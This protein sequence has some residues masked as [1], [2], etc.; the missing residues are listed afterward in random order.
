MTETE[1]S[2]VQAPKKPKRK[3]GKMIK[4]TDAAKYMVS[5]EEK[6]NKLTAL[7]DSLGVKSIKDD[8]EK[9]EL[10]GRLQKQDEVLNPLSGP[11]PACEAY[12]VHYGEALQLRMTEEPGVYEPIPVGMR[13]RQHDM[14]PFLVKDD[15]P[16]NSPFQTGM[17]SNCRSLYTEE[18]Q[19]LLPKKPGKPAAEKARA[20]L[21]RKHAKVLLGISEDHK[22]GGLNEVKE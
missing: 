17:I 2:E 11:G 9:K 7:V 12:K 8:E 16:D 5:L 21:C 20:H 18:Y 3:T 14:I 19:Y 13:V 6:L 10:L 4:V 1:P 22:A 15:T